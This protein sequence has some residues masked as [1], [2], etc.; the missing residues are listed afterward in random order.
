MTAPITSAATSSLLPP[1][2]TRQVTQQQ[3]GQSFDA[4]LSTQLADS[5]TPTDV[6]TGA[7]AIAGYV[8]MP[9]STACSCA[10]CQGASAPPTTAT[11]PATVDP[12]ISSASTLG[13]LVPTSA[14]PQSPSVLDTPER[15]GQ[16]YVDT[17]PATAA[18]LPVAHNTTTASTL[19]ITAESGRA[20]AAAALAIYQATQTSITDSNR[21]P[22]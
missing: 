6:S 12:A 14:A 17:P 22:D 11:S 19:A 18:R 10:A 16:R 5:T 9:V 20:V 8:M 3:A 15:S 2:Q 13:N 7:T 1:T 21:T 4:V